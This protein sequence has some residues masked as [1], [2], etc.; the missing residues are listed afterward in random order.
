M[1]ERFDPVKFNRE[2]R[3]SNWMFGVWFVAGAIVAVGAGFW[4]GMQLFGAASRLPP[5]PAP[6]IVYLPPGWTLTPT[7]PLATKAPPP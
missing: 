2:L 5:S 7:P 4:V 1:N 3:R 6:A